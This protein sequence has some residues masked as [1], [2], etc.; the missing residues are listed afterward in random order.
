MKKKLEKEA[1]GEIETEYP[2]YL[3]SQDTFYVST[4][5]GVGRVY[6]QTFVEAYSNVAQAKLYNMKASLTA[7]DLINDKVIPFFEKQQLPMLRILTDR[8]TEYCGKPDEHDYQLYLAVEGIDHTK[9]QVKHPQINGIGKRFH[10]TILSKFY[11]V[12][13]REKVYTTIEELQIDL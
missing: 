6:Q 9:T 4:L 2:G 10:R 5:K 7:A 8:G 12:A 3:G 1:H 13:F 11:Q